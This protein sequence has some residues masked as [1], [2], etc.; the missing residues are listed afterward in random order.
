MPS[1]LKAIVALLS[2]NDYN[3]LLYIMFLNNIHLSEQTSMKA[4][5][6]DVGYSKRP[7]KTHMTH[8]YKVP[9]TFHTSLMDFFLDRPASIATVSVILL[10]SFPQDV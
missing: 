9:K 6:T 3:P 5:V 7:I 8:H 10:Q 1:L 4:L 2:L